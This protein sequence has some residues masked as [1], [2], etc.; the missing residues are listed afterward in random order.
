MSQ[1]HHICYFFSP[2]CSLVI[3]GSGWSTAHSHSQAHV[4]FLHFHNLGP[5]AFTFD[6]LK[7]EASFDVFLKGSSFANTETSA[8]P[9]GLSGTVSVHSRCTSQKCSRAPLH[10]PPETRRLSWPPTFPPPAAGNVDQI[11]VSQGRHLPLLLT[12]PPTS[13]LILFPSLLH[14]TYRPIF[15]GFLAPWKAI[16][17]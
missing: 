11:K 2:F 1:H 5:L 17:S 16:C 3:S 4:V 10:R 13:G 9:A 14:G 15:C 7:Y 6:L 12:P 8:R